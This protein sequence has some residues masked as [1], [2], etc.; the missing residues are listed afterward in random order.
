M[1]GYKVFNVS[2]DMPELHRQADDDLRSWL[3]RYSL[4]VVDAGI[5]PQSIQNII[6][7]L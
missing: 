6:E 3:K 7:S 4:A 5:S 2:E 1:G